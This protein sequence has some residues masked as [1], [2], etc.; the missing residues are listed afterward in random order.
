MKTACKTEDNGQNLN[1]KTEYCKMSRGQAPVAENEQPAERMIRDRDREESCSLKKRMLIDM[2]HHAPGE[3]M[4]PISPGEIVEPMNRGEG[5]DH[6]P[7]EDMDPIP[8]GEN[9]GS[10]SSPG[11]MGSICLHLEIW[12]PYV[13]TWRYGVHL[14]SPGGMGSISSGVMGSMSSLPSRG[15]HEMKSIPPSKDMK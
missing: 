8:P 1:S 11:G 14:S 13:F 12:G 6:I 10:M 7:P 5:L 9:M 3:G 4:D 2:A 15:R